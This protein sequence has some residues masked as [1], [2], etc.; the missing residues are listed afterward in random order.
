[1]L[2]HISSMTPPQAE[3]WPALLDL[4]EAFPADGCIIGGQMV[5]LLAREH[6]VEPIRATED[7][8]VVIDIRADQGLMKRICAWL[9]ERAFD[10]EG[11][12][13]DTIGHR[14]VS[15]TYT[16]PGK[17]AFDILAPENVGD[18][19]DLTT[20]PPART[21]PAPGTRELLSAGERL[22]QEAVGLSYL[23]RHR[24]WLDSL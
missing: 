16:G 13:A 2:I 19:A 4:Y 11:I 9:E 24:D 10:L 15:T 8:D 20:S 18:R 12:C 5:W 17:V 3:G 7:I 23:V 14:Y 22:A 6:S 1:M 21:V